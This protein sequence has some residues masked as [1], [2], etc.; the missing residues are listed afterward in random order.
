MSGD[1]F[2]PHVEI[3]DYPPGPSQRLELL[4]DRSKR[5]ILVELEMERHSMFKFRSAHGARDNVG[6][7]FQ[8]GRTQFYDAVLCATYVEAFD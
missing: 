2:C 7:W 8:W 5:M 4:A 3:S 1:V 6:Q